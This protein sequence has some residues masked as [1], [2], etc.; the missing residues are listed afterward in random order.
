MAKEFERASIPAV[1]ITAMI[2]LAEQ[3][4]ANRI[5]KGITIPHPCGDPHLPEEEDKAV[6]RQI[7]HTALK[8]LQTEVAGPTLFE[9]G[10]GIATQT[11]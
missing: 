1:L 2:A 8:A 4:K 11:H 9:P 5:V 10:Q 6:R 3:V 7:V